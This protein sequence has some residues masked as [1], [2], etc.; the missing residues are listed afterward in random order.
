MSV[1]SRNK[2]KLFFGENSTNSFLSFNKKTSQPL[3]KLYSSTPTKNKSKPYIPRS[4][5]RPPEI[6]KMRKIIIKKAREK[7]THISFLFNNSEDYFSIFN[8]SSS[9]S[10]QKTEE[11]PE[12]PVFS[13]SHLK[14]KTGS[15]FLNLNIGMGRLESSISYMLDKLAS[16]DICKDIY[17]DHDTQESDFCFTQDIDEFPS[18]DK[19][20]HQKIKSFKTKQSTFLENF[21]NLEFFQLLYK[22]CLEDNLKN[23][24][25]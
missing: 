22:V 23:K 17:K 19:I 8:D 25:A 7:E 3:F 2:I 15:N 18:N 5:Q 24:K 12:K 13:H 16:N 14:D 6:K 4:I 21:K 1:N 9:A 11:N 20:K 10:S